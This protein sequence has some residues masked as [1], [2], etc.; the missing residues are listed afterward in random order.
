MKNPNVKN[1]KINEKVE[2]EM[3][4]KN[5]DM[6]KIRKF[7]L[8]KIYECKEKN[9]M[10]LLASLGDLALCCDVEVYRRRIAFLQRHC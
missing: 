5:F 6:E 1:N 4:K 8:E 10:C 3:K 2:F 7:V 9:T